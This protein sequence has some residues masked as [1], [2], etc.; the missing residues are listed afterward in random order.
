MDYFL[1]LHGLT[2]LYA[3][4]SSEWYYFLDCR[5]S[6]TAENT[7]QYHDTVL[8]LYHPSEYPMHKCMKAAVVRFMESPK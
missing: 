8:S 6:V 7:T 2:Q 1:C 3:V 4:C 5:N